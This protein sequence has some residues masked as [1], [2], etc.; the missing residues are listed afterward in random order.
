FYFAP[1][2][3]WL[4]LNVIALAG[5]IAF[6]ASRE[7]RRFALWALLLVAW[8]Y[9]FYV[10]HDVHIRYYPYA[11][12]MILFGLGL[13]ALA[14]VRPGMLRLTAVLC[15]ASALIVIILLWPRNVPAPTPHQLEEVARYRQAFGRA[16]VVWAEM[17][18]GTI[19]YATGKP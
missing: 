1:S 11:S 13:F 9:A 5:A 4:T 3:A 10:F 14:R 12:A 6:N 17:S 16:D 7:R 18:S 15:T 8:N 2:Q 19:E